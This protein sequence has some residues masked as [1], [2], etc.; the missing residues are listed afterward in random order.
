MAAEADVESIPFLVVKL[1]IEVVNQLI[2]AH[3]MVIVLDISPEAVHQEGN[4]VLAFQAADRS[5]PKSSQVVLSVVRN[6][7][8]AGI[9]G[10]VTCLFLFLQGLADL[11]GQSCSFGSGL[12]DLLQNRR[13]VKLAGQALNFI[14]S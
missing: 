12:A 2:S 1:L 9:E 14:I 13:V 8:E 4:R 11:F 3:F 6:F 5:I 7:T 10:D